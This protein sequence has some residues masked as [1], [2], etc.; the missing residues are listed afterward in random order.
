[1]VF[2]LYSYF[3]S[4]MARRHTDSLLLSDLNQKLARNI[5]WRRFSMDLLRELK[6]LAESV[7]SPTQFDV[8]L[9][10]YH[11]TLSCMDLMPSYLTI[12]LIFAVTLKRYCATLAP[13]RPMRVNAIW[14]L[15]Y[16]THCVTSWSHANNWMN[17]RRS[18]MASLSRSSAKRLPHEGIWDVE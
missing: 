9:W 18:L 4:R 12:K 2:Q 17:C 11:L 5:E 7:T 6:N 16:R 8:N 1:M 14:R 3:R 13:G 10:G 15:L